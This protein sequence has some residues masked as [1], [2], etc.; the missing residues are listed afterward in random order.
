MQIEIDFDVWKTLTAMRS[1][2]DV[3]YNDVLRSMLNLDKSTALA[4][5][6]TEQ[7]YSPLR[8]FQSRNLVLPDGTLL[9]AK[10]KGRM[11]NARIIDGRWVDEEGK[12]HSSPSS[13][14]GAITGTTVNGLRFWEGRRP[15][16]GVWHRLDTLSALQ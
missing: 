15:D 8:D 13:A 11:F 7:N 1:G 12:E 9:R 4:K 14:A 6:S 2:E 16:L 3:S 10:Y 5:N